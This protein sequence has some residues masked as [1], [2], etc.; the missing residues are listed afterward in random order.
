[1]LKLLNVTA[2]T[3]DTIFFLHVQKLKIKYFSNN[4]KKLTLS[5]EHFDIDGALDTNLLTN[6]G[7][8]PAHKTIIVYG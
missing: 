2:A 6:L 3:C 4:H 7:S 1:M 5:C 8:T